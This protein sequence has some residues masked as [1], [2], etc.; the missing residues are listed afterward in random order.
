MQAPYCSQ[1]LESYYAALESSLAQFILTPE[2]PFAKPFCAKSLEMFSM[3]FLE[4]MLTLQ[5]CEDIQAHTLLQE[6]RPFVGT[7][8][9]RTSINLEKQTEQGS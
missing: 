3:S 4:P 5:L 9:Y 6:P 2:G 8:G 1:P 7:W